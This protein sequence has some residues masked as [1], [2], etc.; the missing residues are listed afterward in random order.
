MRATL[1]DTYKKRED[2]ATT[3]VI[4]Q[5]KS[6]LIK[7]G[8][9]KTKRHQGRE[10][11]KMDPCKGMNVGDMGKMKANDDGSMSRKI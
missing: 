4:N 5:D 3:Q 9:N 1:G 11:G 8:Q 7:M 10:G 6:V 2:Y